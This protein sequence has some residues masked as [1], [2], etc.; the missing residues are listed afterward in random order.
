MQYIPVSD[1]KNGKEDG[2]NAIKDT[3]GKL[4][5]G[6]TFNDSNWFYKR[7]FG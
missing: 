6:F 7:K 3:Y 2:E 1:R 5:V 4:T